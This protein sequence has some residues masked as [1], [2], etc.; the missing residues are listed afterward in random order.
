MMLDQLDKILRLSPEQRENIREILTGEPPSEVVSNA[1]TRLE[2]VLSPGQAEQLRRI[3][4]D[5][6]SDV[7][8]Q[9]DSPPPGFLCRS[10]FEYLH[11]QSNGDAYPCCP[12]KFGKIIG[13]LRRQSL[14]EIWRSAAAGEARASMTDGSH[15]FCNAEACEYLRA[16]YQ[17][18]ESVAPAELVAWSGAKGFL[19][20]GSS[21]RII[22]FAHDRSC[23]LACSY[24]R[25]ERF[26]PGPA[27]HNEI[28]L[29]HSNIFASPLP[30]LQ[31]IV[32]LGEGDPFDSE[33]YLEKL[34]RFDWSAY[35]DLRIKIQTNGLLLNP[36]MWRSIASS[37]MAIDWI[38]VSVDGASDQTYRANRGG[39]FQTL[40]RNLH[41][42]ANL[43]AVG[44]IKRFCL[45]FV[46]QANNFHE[47]PEFARLGLNLQAD[48]IEFQRIEN[49]GT[50][51]EAQ[52]RARAVHEPDHPYHAAFVAT[53]ADPILRH[54]SI[55]ML[56]IAGNARRD[57]GMVNWADG[58]PRASQPTEAAK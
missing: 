11:V 40:Q 12:S 13:N 49:W 37:H 28:G 18:A 50:F 6:L 25:A 26:R 14:E 34:R 7:V 10:P 57:V 27:Y 42:I 21:P 47:M 41:F 8:V 55:W 24:C 44:R 46:V 53:L 52:F 56:K 31:R 36:K 30:N 19:N 16:A 54:Q 3:S 39:N 4:A 9:A 38:A 17:Q 48:Q 43:R 5:V 35:P 32:L 22:N 29:I 58:A 20:P 15:R 23:N 45:Y 2:A 51:T 33:F 1:M